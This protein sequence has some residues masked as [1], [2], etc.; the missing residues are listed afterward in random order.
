MSTKFS[1]ECMLVCPSF[2]PN[3]Y[4]MQVQASKVAFNLFQK[5]AS[6]TKRNK[7]RVRDCS[8]LDWQEIFFGRVRDSLQNF[9]LIGTNINNALRGSLRKEMFNQD[10]TSMRGFQNYQ[11]TF[12]ITMY[13]SCTKKLLVQ[14]TATANQTR[15]YTRVPYKY[16]TCTTQTFISNIPTSY[17]R[18]SHAGGLW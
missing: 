5:V 12:G 8:D 16:Y 14:P 17:S 15:L 4:A 2:S 10:I 6:K 18:I 11:T 13:T 9:D 7:F 3:V 1:C